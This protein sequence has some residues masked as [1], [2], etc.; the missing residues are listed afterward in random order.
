MKEMKVDD[1]M[2][3]SP[4]IGLTLP[5]IVPYMS[6]FPIVNRKPIFQTLYQNTSMNGTIQHSEPNK[7][8][9]AKN[10]HFKQVDL[11]KISND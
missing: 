7:D 4:N 1:K 3:E 6:L 5:H 10:L 8:Q 9:L 2:F 11:K